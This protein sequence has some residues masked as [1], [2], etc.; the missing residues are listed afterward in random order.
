MNIEIGLME[1]RFFMKN[2]FTNAVG[3]S[4]EIC[5][6]KIKCGDKVIDA[7]MGNG[8][9]TAFLCQLVG[10][11]G[12]VY[13]FDIQEEAIVN[14]KQRLLNLKLEDR[15]ELI[16]D[17]HE[18]IDQ[19]IKE[20]V[21]LI[22]YN[23][24]YLPKGDHNLTT[25]S[26]TTIE[27]IKK[28]LDMLCENGIIIIVVYPGHENGAQEKLALEGFSNTLNQREFSVVNINF[29]NQVNN[30]PQMTCI[31]KVKKKNYL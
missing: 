15:A 7:T 31:E 30:P 26:D 23:L 4:K 21:A 18:N 13:A 8:N 2:L 24:G 19:Y 25:K 14:T 9:D 3:I 28:G 5:K 11:K 17:G 1:W 29:I 6:E 16:H 22:I 10:P 12:K 27:S 20:D